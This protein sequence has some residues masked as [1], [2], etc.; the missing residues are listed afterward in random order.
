MGM[1][2][3]YKLMASCLAG[4]LGVTRERFERTLERLIRPSPL[5]AIGDPE[6]ATEGIRTPLNAAAVMQAL[7]ELTDIWQ[8]FFCRPD[9][10]K[11]V[12]T[13]LIT[14]KDKILDD[15]G[16][17]PQVL[18]DYHRLAQYLN[19]LRLNRIEENSKLF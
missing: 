18:L 4:G 15:F 5:A 1:Q 3:D 11:D 12:E 10:F 17:N 6:D 8:G 7:R 14:L 9:K 13:H 19:D 16:S 2:T